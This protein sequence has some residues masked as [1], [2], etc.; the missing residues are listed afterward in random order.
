MPV[1]LAPEA[2][3]AW[4]GEEPADE[5]DLKALPV[6]YPSDGMI[7]WP[8]SARRQRQEQPYGPRRVD[9]PY[10]AAR[11]PLRL[12]HD[13]TIAGTP[14]PD[15]PGHGYRGACGLSSGHKNPLRLQPGR[16]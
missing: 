3:P 9:H 11:A 15:E 13:R 7:A 12:K 4:L 5:P 6:P 14:G 16:R 2:W 8:V 1:F 10:L